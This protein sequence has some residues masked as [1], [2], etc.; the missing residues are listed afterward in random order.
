MN[1]QT[2]HT[3]DFLMLAFAVI[4]G[5]LC[6]NMPAGAVTGVSNTVSLYVNN[7]PDVSLS[8]DS[9][10]IYANG[11]ATDIVATVAPGGDGTVAADAYTWT[12]SM[13][14]GTTWVAAGGAGSTATYSP[15]TNLTQTTLYRCS[16][17]DDNGLSGYD[18]ATVIV[19]SAPSATIAP[20]GETE[21]NPGGVITWTATPSG[22]WGAT[23][24]YTITWQKSATPAVPASWVPVVADAEHV[25]SGAIGNVLTIDPIAESDQMSY[26]CIVN[27]GH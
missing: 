12:Q 14:G 23:P 15:P 21:A 1:A 17:I 25:I 3:N 4:L 13:D 20:S 27:D 9:Q 26:R 24:T 10:E 2:R 11:T 19:Y 22:G 6:I 7:P 16:V 5:L 8:P 18:T